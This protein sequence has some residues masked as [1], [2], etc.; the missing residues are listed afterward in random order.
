MIR[1]G[2]KITSLSIENK[3]TTFTTNN[4]T[5]RVICV[6]LESLFK[7]NGIVDYG[8]P[9]LFHHTK[10]FLPRDVWKNIVDMIDLWE[11]V[12]DH[13]SSVSPHTIKPPQPKVKEVWTVFKLTY[14]VST[15]LQ[16]LL[17]SD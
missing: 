10:L 14:V 5:F 2:D 16:T 15:F 13:W 9:I 12:G 1:T 7:G 11:V 8:I 4:R 3:T 6:P 17:H